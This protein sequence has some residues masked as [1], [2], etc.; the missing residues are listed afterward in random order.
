M[1]GLHRSSSLVLGEGS[2]GRGNGSPTPGRPPPSSLDVLK[3]TALS[4]A[5]VVSTQPVDATAACDTTRARAGFFRRRGRAADATAVP[6]ARCRACLPVLV[7]PARPRCSVHRSPDL[8][9]GSG[10]RGN[11]SPTPGRPHPSSLDVLKSAALSADATADR[12][13]CTASLSV[14]V[15]PA[16]PRCSVH[17]PPRPSAG[18]SAKKKGSTLRRDGYA[19]CCL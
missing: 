8:G 2:G 6:G 15:M 17:R 10:G 12:A 13:R 1:A 11:G 14:L 7:M 5:A 16:R 9:E 19:G 18:Q 3:S 4:A